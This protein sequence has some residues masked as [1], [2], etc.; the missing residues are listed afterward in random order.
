MVTKAIMVCGVGGV[1]LPGPT[2]TGAEWLRRHHVA[3]QT[4]RGPEIAITA[5]RSGLLAYGLEYAE[6]FEGC[7]LGGDSF[8]G[9]AWLEMSRSY[10]ALLNGPTGRLDCGTLDGEVRRWANGFG[11]TEEL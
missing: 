9:P 2:A 3:L 5:F 4:P 10:I 7:K 1:N 6:Q 11:F 8:L